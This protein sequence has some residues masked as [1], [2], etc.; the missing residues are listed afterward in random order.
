MSCA[1]ACAIYPAVVHRP[2][3]DPVSMGLPPISTQAGSDLVA[4]ESLPWGPAFKVSLIEHSFLA[5]VRPAP[6]KVATAGPPLKGAGRTL[7]S[8]PYG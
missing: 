6:V 3:T 4:A 1:R 2:V 5:R 7:V 8:R